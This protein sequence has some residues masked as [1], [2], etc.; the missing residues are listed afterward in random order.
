MWWGL[1]A[2]KMSYDLMF[3]VTWGL[4]GA[5]LVIAAPV[6]FLRIKDTVAIDEDLKFTDKT[7]E[8]V[9]VGGADPKGE[10]RA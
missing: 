4:L 5:S 3:A 8:D 7:I 2:D 1:D 6:I 10:A 9:I